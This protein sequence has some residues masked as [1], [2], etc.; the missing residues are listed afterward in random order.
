MPGNRDKGLS[1]EIEARA[2]L[3]RR[4]LRCLA[5][6]FHCR[7][8]EIDLVMRDGEAVCFVE[9]KYR[10]SHAFG[11]AAFALPP[12]KRRKLIKAAQCYV[13]ANRNFA[14]A[15]LRFDALLIQRQADGSD[16]IDWIRNAFQVDEEIE[17]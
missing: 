7:F 1:G 17:Q 13:A 6:N 11:G 8:G 12:A 2:F 15:P 4:G 16:E 3:E 9:V 5:Q 14:A 10:G